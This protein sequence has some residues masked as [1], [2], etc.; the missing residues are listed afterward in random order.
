MSQYRSLALDC[1]AGRYGAAHHPIAR[2][3]ASIPARRCVNGGITSDRADRRGVPWRCRAAAGADRR[4]EATGSRS[5]DR[6]SVAS[7]ADVHKTAHVVGGVHQAD[8]GSTSMNSTPVV[9]NLDWNDVLLLQ[10]SL[11]GLKWLQKKH[12]GHISLFRHSGKEAGMSRHFVA[13]CLMA[14][15]IAT[16]LGGIA[17]QAKCRTDA[18]V[19]CISF[20]GVGLLCR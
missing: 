10:L 15:G 16:M 4:P 11:L 6:D 12:T 14:V 18:M 7:I 5:W 19:C 9:S 2:I 17:L 8:D 13:I 20:A 1:R 3:A